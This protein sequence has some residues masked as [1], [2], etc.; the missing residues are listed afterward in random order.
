RL[1]LK[2]FHIPDIST[3]M[4]INGPAPILLAMYFVAAQ[5]I[6]LERAEQEL[7]R[8]LAADEQ[9]V[10][11]R[12]TLQLLRGTLQGDILKEVQAQNENIF[13]PDFAIRLLGDIQEWF[14]ANDVRKFYSLSISGYHI[15][16]AGAS[17]VQELAFTLANGFTYVENFLARG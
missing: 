1:V 3:S 6:E 16:E 2:G 8:Q 13:Q 12:K 14:I 5:E 7:G 15:G 10:L 11:H 9:E 17:P 4:T